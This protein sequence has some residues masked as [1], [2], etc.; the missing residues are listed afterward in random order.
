MIF[1]KG[2]ERLRRLNCLQAKMSFHYKSP[3]SNFWVFLKFEFGYLNLQIFP[4]QSYKIRLLYYLRGLD[5]SHL[6]FGYQFSIS[7][8]PALICL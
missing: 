6:C 4:M 1:G 7:L 2:G 8:I 3:H 5:L